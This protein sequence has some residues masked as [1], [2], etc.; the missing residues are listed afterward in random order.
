MMMRKAL[1]AAA[2]GLGLSALVPVP[3][4]YLKD[5]TAHAL[6]EVFIGTDALV[7]RR[8]R[9]LDRLERG[10]REDR[11]RLPQCAATDCFTPSEAAAVA[12]QKG[13]GERTQGRF[14]LDVRGGTGPSD[15]HQ[16]HTEDLFYLSSFRRFTGFGTL[17]VAIAPDALS[18][19]MADSAV[20]GIK[21]RADRPSVSRMMKQFGGQ[22][23][24]VDGEVSLQWIEFRDWESGQRNGQG[25]HQVWVR[26]TSPE[27]ITVVG[28]A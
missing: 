25:Y 1:I 16:L 24:I 4:P 20:S 9:Q 22:R 2:C 23:V 27:Q 8:I 15:P 11:A 28:P 19:L 18:D 7:N 6:S 17:V 21:D 26:V 12:F 10:L 3:L 13:P 5:G 14:I